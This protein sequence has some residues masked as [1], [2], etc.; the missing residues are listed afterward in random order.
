[1]QREG[2]EASFRQK[3]RTAAGCGRG[4]DGLLNCTGVDSL[5]IAFG[6]ILPNVERIGRVGA[7]RGEWQHG[8]ARSVQKL[9]AANQ[10]PIGALIFHY[11]EAHRVFPPNGAC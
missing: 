3:N 7:C 5:A 4:V 1:M 6:T 10:T 8:K 2:E 9:P 11:D